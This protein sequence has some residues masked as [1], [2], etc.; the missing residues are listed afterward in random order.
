MN[1]VNRFNVTQKESI[2]MSFMWAFT[3]KHKPPALKKI[4]LQPKN[5]TTLLTSGLQKVT[6]VA[7][8]I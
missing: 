8:K 3:A 7:N 4:I 5:L 2:I 6:S 1:F